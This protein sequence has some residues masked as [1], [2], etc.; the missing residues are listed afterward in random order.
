[1]EEN[2]IAVS[3][4][5]AFC[6]AC[7]PGVPCFNRCCADL[8]Q[9]LYPYDILR[10]KKHLGLTSQE[11]LQRYTSQHIGPQSGLPVIALKPAES[12]DLLCPFATDRGCRVYADRPASCRMYPLLR[13]VSRCRKTGRITEH[14]AMIKEPHCRGFES[15][16]QLQVA[17]WLSEQGLGDYNRSNDKILELI[18]LKNRRLLG[19]LDLKS[20]RLF[21]LALYDLDSFKHH[22][23]DG[24]LFRQLPTDAE[25]L[26]IARHDD[27]VLLDAAF[28]WVKAS[29]FGEEDGLV[30]NPSIRE[31]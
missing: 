8:N 14:F 1:M 27:T 24:G 2:L 11:F 19:P 6:F 9:F 25:T 7:H 29:L 22:V 28:E 13:V 15:D 3:A 5:D 21:H 23:F 17:Q 31:R 26:E 16:N 10:L 20:Q 30:I 12:N 4:E 18:G